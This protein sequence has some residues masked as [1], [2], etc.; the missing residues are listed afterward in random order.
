M[1]V[2]RL[3][4]SRSTSSVRV[5]SPC[6]GVVGD[7]AVSKGKTQNKTSPTSAKTC[8]PALYLFLVLLFQCWA[9]QWKQG[10]MVKF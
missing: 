9:F 4:W 3:Q 5:I 10:D 6:R 7:T 8:L 1:Y 2:N